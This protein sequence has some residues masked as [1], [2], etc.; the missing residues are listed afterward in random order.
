VID[1]Y[2]IAPA[3]V[4]AMISNPRSGSTAM[5]L[6]RGW[7]GAEITDTPSRGLAPNR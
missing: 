5:T 7:A 1:D 6:A 4:V 2:R 3:Y